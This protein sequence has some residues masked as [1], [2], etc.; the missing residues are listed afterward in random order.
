MG[1]QIT[2]YN[3]NFCNQ[4]SGPNVQEGDKFAGAGPQSN[5]SA[6]K[7]SVSSLGNQVFRASPRGSATCF[8]E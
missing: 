6:I 4:V 3:A 8:L 2:R 1:K 7:L 5:N